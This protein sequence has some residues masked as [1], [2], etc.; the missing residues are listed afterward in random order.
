MRTKKPPWWP[1]GDDTLPHF[2][3]REFDDLPWPECAPFLTVADLAVDV[4]D[5][6]CRERGC[7]PRGGGR[8]TLSDWVRLTFSSSVC[9]A[10]VIEA[11]LNCMG[12]RLG[13]DLHYHHM[14]EMPPR[15]T[16]RLLAEAWNSVLRALGYEQD[17]AAGSIEDRVDDA[18]A[19]VASEHASA[20]LD[21]V[22]RVSQQIAAMTPHKKDRSRD[23]R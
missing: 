3:T 2:G 11:L 19:S 15:G 4:E 5:E 16:L 12:S 10:L 7:P 18:S 21:E 23:R 13:T 22:L 6:G 1:N 14:S 20:L 8:F 9:A 17:G